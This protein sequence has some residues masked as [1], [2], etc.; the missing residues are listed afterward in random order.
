MFN[1]AA[2]TVAL[3]VATHF[4]FSE[5]RP[6]TAFI[7]LVVLFLVWFVGDVI[8]LAVGQARTIWVFV[9]FNAVFIVAGGFAAGIAAR[10]DLLEEIGIS[11]FP[12]LSFLVLVWIAGNVIMLIAARLRRVDRRSLTKHPDP[13]R[14]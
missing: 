12:A 1:V 11:A 10:F 6:H 3:Y 7:L 13:H 4:G 5:E 14:C 8:L 9:V 2:G